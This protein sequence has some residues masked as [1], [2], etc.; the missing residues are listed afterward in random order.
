MLLKE[1]FGHERADSEKRDKLDY[2]DLLCN[3]FCCCIMS[4]RAGHPYLE[5][6]GISQAASTEGV[7]ESRHAVL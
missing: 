3:L 4:L 5:P 6:G 2:V 1:Y 7:E